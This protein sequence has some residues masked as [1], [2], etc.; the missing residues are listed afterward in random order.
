MSTPD[1]SARL[2]AYVDAALD[3]VYETLFALT[4]LLAEQRRR[5]TSSTLR[6]VALS[7]LIT[8]QLEQLDLRDLSGGAR[9]DSIPGSDPA[10]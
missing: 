1:S 10:A 5:A 8:D 6:V 4:D 7:A 3:P 2:R 9:D